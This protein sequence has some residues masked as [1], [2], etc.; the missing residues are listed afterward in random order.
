MEDRAQGSVLNGAKGFRFRS[1]VGTKIYSAKTRSTQHMTRNG[2]KPRKQIIE[3][4][5]VRR[6]WG[7]VVASEQAEVPVKPEGEKADL[8]RRDGG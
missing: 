8:D 6:E 7:A 1:C 4:M 2:E 5:A 3:A